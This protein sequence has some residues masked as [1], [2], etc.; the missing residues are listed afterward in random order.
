NIQNLSDTDKEHLDHYISDKNYVYALVEN[1]PMEHAVANYT[2]NNRIDMLSLIVQKESF[3]ER[4]FM[5]SSTTKINQHVQ[6]PLLIFH[7]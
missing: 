2:K 1:I 6:W 4:L 3:L 5:G 7:S